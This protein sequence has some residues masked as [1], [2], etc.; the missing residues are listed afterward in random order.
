MDDDILEA[1]NLL[2]KSASASDPELKEKLLLEAVDVLNSIDTDSI[3]DKDAT[4][5]KNIRLAHTR[6]IIKQLSIVNDVD[7][8]SYLLYLYIL[9]TEFKPEVDCC[10]EADK[11][12]KERFRGFVKQYLDGL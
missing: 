1:R 4:L 10:L 8:P 5:I 12:L 3:S 2:E 11:A 6:N 9:A 7:M